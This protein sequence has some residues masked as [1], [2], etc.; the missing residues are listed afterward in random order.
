[1]TVFNVTADGRKS[2]AE[3]LNL[4]SIFLDMLQL[5]LIEINANIA[6]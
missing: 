6:R 1:M 5:Y 4:N 2:K 3:I